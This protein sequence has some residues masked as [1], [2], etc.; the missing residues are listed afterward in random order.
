M[1]ALAERQAPE[2]RLQA[3]EQHVQIAAHDFIFLLSDAFNRKDL[4]AILALRKR[5]G[6]C[7]EAMHVVESMALDFMDRTER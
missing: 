2:T 6:L 4:S 3:Q 1:S 7:V 5:I